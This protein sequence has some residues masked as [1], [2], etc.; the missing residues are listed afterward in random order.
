M[1]K[2]K[3]FIFTDK[4]GSTVCTLSGRDLDLYEMIKKCETL[5][6]TDVYN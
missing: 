2:Y 4:K 6:E 3:S 5:R 1:N